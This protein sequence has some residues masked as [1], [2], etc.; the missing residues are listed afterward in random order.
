MSDLVSLGYEKEDFI[1][2]AGDTY[3]LDEQKEYYTRRPEIQGKEVSGVAYQEASKKLLYTELYIKADYDLD[4]YSE[5]R[6]VCIVGPNFDKIIMNEP[7][8]EFP[9]VHMTPYREPH[10]VVGS[11]LFDFLYSSLLERYDLE[12]SL[13]KLSF[14][15]VVQGTAVS[16]S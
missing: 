11:G 15:K 4:D 13:E 6:R 7:C 1:D 2:F 14:C 8:N 3:D 12:R 10:D 5:I 9:F 16:G